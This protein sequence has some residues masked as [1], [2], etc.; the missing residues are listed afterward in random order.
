M[1]KL[2]SPGLPR[3]VFSSLSVVSTEC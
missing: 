3:P 2:N 1:P